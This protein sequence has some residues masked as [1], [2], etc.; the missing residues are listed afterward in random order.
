EAT[1][2]L[3]LLMPRRRFVLRLAGILAIVVLLSSLAAIDARWG[4][5]NRAVV[6]A[7]AADARISPVTVGLPMFTLPEGT[8][9]SIEK[10]YG[11]FALVS[12]GNGRRGWVNRET[13]EP[14]I[15]PAS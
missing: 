6:T 13:I 4:E 8:V 2:P 5:L 3:A 9:V 11:S 7:K 1:L 10:S 14:V 12:A 15:R